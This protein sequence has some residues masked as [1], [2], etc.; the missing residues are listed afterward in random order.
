MTFQVPKEKGVEL[1]RSFLDS[2]RRVVVKVGSAVLTT[3]SGLNQTVL[4]NLAQDLTFLRESGREVILVSSGAVASGRKKLGLDNRVLKMREKQ[5]AAAVGQSSLMRSYEDLFERYDQKVAQVLL[6][7]D[8]LAHRHRYLNVRNTMA[9][10]FEWG[11]LPIINENDTVSVKELRFGDNDTLGAMVTNL[12]DADIFICLTDVDGLYT[13][14]PCTNPQAQRVQT[15][16][17]VTA[18]VENMAG[19]ICGSTLGTGG[20]RSKILAARMVAA[21]GGCSFIGP[22]REPSVLRKLF[23][24]EPV[25]TFFLPKPQKLASRKHWIAYTLRPKGFLVLDE[26]ACRALLEQGKSLL[27]SGIREVRGKFG[28]GDPVHCLNGDGRAVAAGLVNY[29]ADDI[30]RIHGCQTSE[31]EEILGFKD[32]DEV[33]HRDNLV[34]L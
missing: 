10:L 4:E 13:G 1:R 34:K 5:A 20:M 32:S 25:G 14:N 15:V 23:S 16:A 24:G 19:N 30:E 17:E 3:G 7:H 29:K 22:G 6:T 12:I 8:D 11:I 2:A 33:I 26:G 28:V 27:P 31:I 21:R 9:T 18:Q